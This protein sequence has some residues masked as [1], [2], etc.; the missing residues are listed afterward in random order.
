[1][2]AKSKGRKSRTN[3]KCPRLDENPGKNKTQAHRKSKPEPMLEKIHGKEHI[4]PVNGKEQSVPVQMTWDV[5]ETCK[6]TL[7]EDM[8]VTELHAS[9]ETSDESC[10]HGDYQFVSPPESALVPVTKTT[11]SNSQRS[12]QRGGSIV[13]EHPNCSTSTHANLSFTTPV[14]GDYLQNGCHCSMNSESE[15]YFSE[16]SDEIV[17]NIFKWLP[18]AELGQCAR[19]CRRWNSLICDE[20]LWKKINLSGK[21]FKE[22][23]LGRILLRGAIAVKLTKS[24][25]IA[26]PFDSKVA[27]ELNREEEV[28]ILRRKPRRSIRVQYLDMSQC[29]QEAD[30]LADVLRYCHQ[31]CKVSLEFCKINDRVLRSFKEPANL[32]V[33]NLC[34][35][36]GLSPSGIGRL[37]SGCSNLMALNIS[38]CEVSR[39]GLSAV[40]NNL[41]S[42]LQK[43]NISGYRHVL[44]DEDVILIT[45]RCP[46]LIELDL[47]DSALVTPLSVQCIMERLNKLLFLALSRCYNVPAA[48]LVQLGAMPNLVALNIFG[49]LH[50]DG[51]QMLKTSMPQVEINKYPFSSIAR[52]TTGLRRSSIWGVKC[53]D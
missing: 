50:E 11:T 8:G 30:T 47:S 33:L 40:L 43:L 14:L 51:L 13:H 17:L 20:T 48:V 2:A 27:T 46:N 6:K 3:A 18:L 9:S 32:Q 7:Y 53:Y 36:S 38:W 25:I 35:C 4:V 37:L 31:L 44:T 5:D 45:L 1:M 23:Q 15:D 10:G 28:I 52:P 39:P 21:T 16:L 22:G 26:P 42:S 24:E 34:M 41:P 12:L 19:I 29:Q 49:L